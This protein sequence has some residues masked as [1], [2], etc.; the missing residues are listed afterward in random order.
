VTGLANYSAHSIWVTVLVETGLVGFCVWLA[1]LVYLLASAAVMRLSGDR[2]ASLLGYGW[3]AALIG[4]S[5]ANLFYLT[6][7][8]D[9]FFAVALFAVAGAALFGPAPVPAAADRGT[10]QPV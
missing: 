1:Y 5:I 2:D 10:P 3:L 6:M 9:Y 7:L 8:F 4:T